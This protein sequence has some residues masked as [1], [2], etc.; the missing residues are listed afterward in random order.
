MSDIYTRRIALVGTERM[1]RIN[2][3]YVYEREADG[4]WKQFERL[5]DDELRLAYEGV[6]VEWQHDHVD[7]LELKRRFDAVYPWKPTGRGLD[8]D[9]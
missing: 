8:A 7:V 9:A 4:P 2:D 6:F 5:S 3:P 1:G